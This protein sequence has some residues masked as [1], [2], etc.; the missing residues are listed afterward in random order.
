MNHNQI[1][2]EISIIK[3][4][5]DKTRRETAE[6]GNL[7]IFIGLFSAVITLLIGLLEI[8]NLNHLV[9]P[10]I[11]IMSIGNGIVGYL[12]A[13]KENK[14]E[15]YPKTIFWKV[16]VVCGFTAVLIVFLFPFLN[17]YSFRAVPVLVSLIMGIALFISGIVYELKFIQVSSSAW[18]AGAL[19]LSLTDSQ[20]RFLIVVAVII[21]GW[22]IPGFILNRRFRNGIG[23]NES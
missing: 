8:Y 1:Q 7:F 17:V 9:L 21:V 10:A 3:E 14:V 6:S 22:I 11:I 16:W 23:E 15:T 4:M 12:I 18:F 13:S 20:Y 19:L 5:I 2:Q